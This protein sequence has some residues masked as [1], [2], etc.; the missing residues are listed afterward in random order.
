M[1]NITPQLLIPDWPAP[2]AVRSLVTTR[3]CGASQVPYDHFN[4]ALHVGDDAEQV[5]ANRQ[6]LKDEFALQHIQWLDQVHGTDV[7]AAQYTAAEVESVEEAVDE[8]VPKADAVVTSQ[9]QLACAVMTADCLPV[10]LCSKQGDWV[11]AAH[12]G[13]RGLAAG[14]L[15]QLVCGYTGEKQNLMAWL[16]P[17]IGPQ[18]FEVGPEVREAF[19]YLGID[20][21]TAFQPSNRP[22]HYFADL[23]LL[24]KLQLGQL[25]IDQVYGGGFCTYRDQQRFYSYRRSTQTGRMA[26]LIWREES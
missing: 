14:I 8:I 6:W 11:G 19:Q 21:E 12:A 25:G 10:L 15:Q 5:K 13:W 4:L 17:A 23:Y 18:H 26:S 9:P 2:T 20:A 24:A 3:Q 22:G 7:I 1:E 16:G